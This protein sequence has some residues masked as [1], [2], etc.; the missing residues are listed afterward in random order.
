VLPGSRGLFQRALI[1][2]AVGLQY[3]SPAENLETATTLASIL[4]CSGMPA[5]QNAVNKSYSI[6]IFDFHQRQK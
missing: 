6:I 5:C 1:E 2:S 4:R 3:R